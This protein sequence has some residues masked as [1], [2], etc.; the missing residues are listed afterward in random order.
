MQELQ[1]SRRENQWHPRVKISVVKRAPHHYLGIQII[2]HL[3]ITQR[4]PVQ[5]GSQQGQNRFE[6]YVVEIDASVG[7]NR[8]GRS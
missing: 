2:H 6:A 1:A 7:W 5:G 3:I 8:L 4:N